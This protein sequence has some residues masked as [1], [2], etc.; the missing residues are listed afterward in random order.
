MSN[1]TGQGGTPS[2]GSGS[3][4][5]IGTVQPPSPGF[6]LDNGTLTFFDGASNRVMDFN[7]GVPSSRFGTPLP[8][9]I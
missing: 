9:D 1:T 3:S 2:G 7:E 6:W 4:S 8:G 5:N